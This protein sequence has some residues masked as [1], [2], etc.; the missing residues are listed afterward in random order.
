MGVDLG[1]T[2]LATLSTGETFVGPK[3]LKSALV[4]VKR[5]ARS[6]SRKVKGSR[7]YAK[8][9]MRLARL[10][11]GSPDRRIADIRRDGLHKLTTS[12]SRRFQ[13]IGITPRR[14]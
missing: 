7:N 10:Y 8:A 12:I 6:L 14:R 2:A 3:A 9:K 11:A 4:R 1:V 5:L 13:I